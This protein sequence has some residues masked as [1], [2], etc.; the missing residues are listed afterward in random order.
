MS[1]LPI[2]A[3]LSVSL[4]FQQADTHT[5][6]YFCTRRYVCIVYSYV[7]VYILA[8]AYLMLSPR[9]K[10]LSFGVRDTVPP[11]PRLSTAH[12]LLSFSPCQQA[13]FICC[14]YFANMS[15]LSFV[16]V[17]YHTHSLYLLLSI[18]CAPL[19]S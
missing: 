7:L 19:T 8:V 12:L 4:P 13:A 1:S 3:H 10:A 16:L 9:F 5:E 2:S 18:T 14:F 15:T 6:S 17:L 11:E